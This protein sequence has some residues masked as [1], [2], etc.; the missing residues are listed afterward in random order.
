MGHQPAER[1]DQPEHR[2]EKVLL[3]AADV[4]QALDA[5]ADW[6][7]DRGEC[8]EGVGMKVPPIINAFSAASGHS[9]W[10][11]GAVN[12]TVAAHSNSGSERVTLTTSAGV[13]Q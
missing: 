6:T 12:R 2:V 8:G 3:H 7:F 1:A 13:E 4:E 5:L 10:A 9:A 11:C